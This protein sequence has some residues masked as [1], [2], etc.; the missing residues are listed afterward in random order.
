MAD[1]LGCGMSSDI[2]LWN[3]QH[4]RPG[5]LLPDIGSIEEPRRS[6]RGSTLL[7][8]DIQ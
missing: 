5:S 3:V 4:V 2:G 7:A 6:D 1:I 8:P